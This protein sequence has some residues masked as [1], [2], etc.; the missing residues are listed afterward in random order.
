MKKD[1]FTIRL[2]S[3]LAVQDGLVPASAVGLTIK[4]SLTPIK[5]QLKPERFALRKQKGVFHVK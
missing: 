1:V 5:N 4:Q 3:L 2:I